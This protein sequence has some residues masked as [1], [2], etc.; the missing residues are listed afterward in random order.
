MPGGQ[1]QPKMG[2]GMQPG[3]VNDMLQSLI[4]QVQNSGGISAL[5]NES[6]RAQVLQALQSNPQLVQAL[7]QKMQSGQLP[8][9]ASFLSSAASVPGMQPSSSVGGL[10]PAPHAHPV[11]SSYPGGSYSAGLPPQPSASA[12]GMAGQSMG[13]SYG[14]MEGQLMGGGQSA[15]PSLDVN[16]LKD[17]L[18]ATAPLLGQGSVLP[19]SSQPMQQGSSQLQAS[20]RAYESET[21]SASA[22]SNADL[23]SFLTRGSSGAGASS[24]DAQGYMPQQPSQQPSASQAGRSSYPPI[25]PSGRPGGAGPPGAQRFGR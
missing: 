19:Q 4:Q 13:M 3:A 9:A 2:S 7:V 24:S 17:L 16:S 12:S 15:S 25:V 23:L 10:A 14:G 11:A 21:S 1:T 6:T 5:S 18:A 20:S 8:S 22:P